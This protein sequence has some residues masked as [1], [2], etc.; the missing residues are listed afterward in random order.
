MKTIFLGVG[1]AC[2]ERLPNTSILVRTGTVA[3][4]ASVLLDCGFTAPPQY[5]RVMEHPDELDALWI[6]HFHGDHFF[7]VPALI[8]RFWEMKRKK[9]LTIIGQTGVGSIVENAMEL[10]YP[11]FLEKLEYSLH[12]ME[13]EPGDRIEAAGLRWSF[14]ENGHGK[15]DLAVRIDDG[16]SS[17]FYSGDGMPTDATL[18]LARGCSLIVHEAFMLYRP[19]ANHGSI[20]G[21]VEFAGRAEAERLAVVHVQR[22]ERRTRHEE[23]SQFIGKVGDRTVFLPEPGDSLEI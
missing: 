17:L 2:D 1:E 20:A 12:F 22:D 23:I 19:I 6:S 15:R 16:K 4:S 18:E 11:S 14:A 8:L 21:C 9:T 13:V 7:G 10:A 5:W 3:D